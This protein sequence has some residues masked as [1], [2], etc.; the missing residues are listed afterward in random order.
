M[1]Q[2]TEGRKQIPGRVWNCVIEFTA[3]DLHYRPTLVSQ[4][5]PFTERGRALAYDTKV[6]ES[7]HVAT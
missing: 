4:A 6:H 3:I 1:F 7:F 5:T 2:Q